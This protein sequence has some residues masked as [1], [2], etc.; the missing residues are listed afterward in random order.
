MHKTEQSRG[1]LGRFLGPLLKTGLELIGNLLKPLSKTAVIPLG[2]T[3]TASA[4][5]AAIDKK[6]F[7]SDTTTLIIS[8]VEMNDVMK[9]V[10]S[11]EES[12]LLIKEV[13]ETITNEAKEQQE[14]FLGMLLGNLG[15][16]LLRN[17][18]TGKGV[19][20]AGEGTN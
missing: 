20:R 8:N 12:G 6:M 17:L 7:G 19:I 14:E 9:I 3:A 18:L 5:D 2:L 11:L 10:K 15:A 16:N 4:T 13:I 1:F